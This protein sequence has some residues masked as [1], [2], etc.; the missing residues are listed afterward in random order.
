MNETWLA[1]IELINTVLLQRLKRRTRRVQPLSSWL[2]GSL[3]IDK[4][5]TAAAHNDCAAKAHLSFRVSPRG[6][7]DQST[8]AKRVARFGVTTQWHR[9]C[10]EEAYVY[11][12]SISSRASRW[13]HHIA[14]ED[15]RLKAFSSC[16]SGLLKAAQRRGLCL[17]A[18]LTQRLNPAIVFKS[19]A[20]TGRQSKREFKP[21]R[22]QSNNK[23]TIESQS[24][25]FV[26][27]PWRK[28]KI[29][30][31]TRRTAVMLKNASMR[32]MG[33][34]LKWPFASNSHLLIVHSYPASR[35]LVNFANMFL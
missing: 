4:G 24:E 33:N 13:G 20:N 31:A 30:Y 22:W 1:S 2:S 19:E 7:G 8:E 34:W 32:R 35:T 29:Q 26:I 23:V 21:A 9:G 14:A 18:V 15:L 10:R 16:S 25:P 11:R 17:I 5:F 3:P 27:C 12:Q 6:C 28:L